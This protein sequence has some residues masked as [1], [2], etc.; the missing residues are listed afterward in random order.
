MYDDKPEA[1]VNSETLLFPDALPNEPVLS[2]QQHG[3]HGITIEQH[4]QPPFEIP[5]HSLPTHLIAIQTGAPIKVDNI[6]NGRFQSGYS[7]RGDLSILPAHLPNW[8]RWYGIAEYIALRLEPALMVQLIK[9]ELINDKVEIIPHLRIRDPL[10][11]QLG[12]GLLKEAKAIGMMSRLYAESTSIL[13]AIHL[14]K[15]YSTAKMA[16]HYH[17]DGLPKSKLHQVIEY[18][19]EN[20]ERDLSLTELAAIAG[21]SPNYFANTFKRLTGVPP[22]QYVTNCRIERAKALLAEDKLPITE[23]CH[24]IGFQS[25]S[26]FSTVFRRLIGA[27][28][29]AYR[30]QTKQ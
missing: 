22:H 19:D 14:L 23:I 6:V 16:V 5:E 4:C 11:E 7:V 1:V 25:H 28:P 20:L 24:R 12:I 15:H 8:E 18:I 21:L 27:T 17:L 26:H 29:K 30:E 3:W 13:I 9:Q 2:S 10:I